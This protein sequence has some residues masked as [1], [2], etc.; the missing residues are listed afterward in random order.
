VIDL[1][2]SDCELHPSAFFWR[3]PLSAS[4]IE[5]WG[6]RRSISAP[7]DLKQLWSR[8]GGGDLFESETILQP[9]GA[10]EYDLIESVSSASWAKGLS[11]DYCV[12]HTGIVESVFRKSD[13]AIFALLSGD[14]TQMVQ[15][16]DLDEWY[17]RILRSEFATRY[18]LKAE[19]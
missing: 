10:D 15:F 9:F 1:I 18:G 17:V 16:R 11:S 2:L 13:G 5:D 19:L 12:F 8:K 4:E 7:I 6:A 3:G 14:I